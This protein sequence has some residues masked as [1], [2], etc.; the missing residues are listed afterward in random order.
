MGDCLMAATLGIPK[1]T[2]ENWESGVN[3]PPIYVENLIIADIKRRLSPC[4]PKFSITDENVRVYAD[5][6]KQFS[7]DTSEWSYLPDD[8]FFTTKGTGWDETFGNEHD[9]VDVSWAFK[10][11]DIDIEY[12]ACEKLYKYLLEEIQLAVDDKWDID[13]LQMTVD[14]FRFN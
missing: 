2:I 11:E 9:G 14:K 10:L 13:S 1:R 6:C 5:I 8:H 3:I 7:H 4:I 12:L